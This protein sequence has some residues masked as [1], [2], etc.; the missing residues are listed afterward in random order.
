M[1]T[2]A[3]GG[4]PIANVFIGTTQAKRMFMGSKLIWMPAHAEET[5]PFT[6]V[7]AH[8]FTIPEWCTHLDVVLIGGGGGGCGGAAANVAGMEGFA[9]SWN[10]LTIERG[11]QITW[12]A[13]TIAV[14]VGAGGTG[15][16]GG[17]A[18]ALDR[19]MLGQD[20]KPSTCTTVSLTAAGGL[21]AHSVQMPP[22]TVNINAWNNGAGNKVFNRKTYIGAVAFQGMSAMNKAGKT[23]GGGA[24]GGAGGLFGGQAA[25]A[26]GVGGAWIRAYQQF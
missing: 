2:Y 3:G 23:P 12:D 6:T 1:T 15:G 19:R 26:G 9:G 21:A 22:Y 7:G 16:K 11:N 20:G 24:P 13:T 8:S 17:N 18:A 10:A 5:T 4:R 25:G 14:E